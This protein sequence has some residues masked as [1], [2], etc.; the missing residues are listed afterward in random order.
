MSALGITFGPEDY[1]YVDA[2]PSQAWTASLETVAPNITSLVAEQRMQ[3]ESWI[4]ALERI[5][6]AVVSTWQQK[7]IMQVQVERAKQ[8]L[9]PL[10]ASQLAAGVNVGLSPEVQRMVW[11]GGGALLLALVYV[12][13][14]RRR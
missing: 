10:D 12:A 1:A 5:L 7:E 2:V 13:T 11:I 6:P 8:G 3:S 9:P 14:Q 4:D